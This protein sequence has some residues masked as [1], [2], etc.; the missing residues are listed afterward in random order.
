[1]VEKIIIATK[2]EGKVKEFQ[3][4]FQNM[5]FEILSLL[6]IDDS[7]DIEETGNTFKENAILKAEGIAN[8]LNVMVIADDSGLSIDALGGKPGIFSARY[9]G[10]HKND[11]DNMNQVL[12]EL[13]T[14]PMTDRTARFHCALALAIPFKQTVVVEG[15]C[16]GIITRKPVGE[17]GFG[18]DPIFYIKEAD[19]TMAELTKEEKNQISHRASALKK[20]SKKI[21]IIWSGK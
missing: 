18:Y 8:I 11:L 7:P 20:L 13:I 3:S 5:G 9:A 10:L 16:E 2:N 21:N 1:M 4:L 14:V 19:K 17:N 12:E 6:D 15:T